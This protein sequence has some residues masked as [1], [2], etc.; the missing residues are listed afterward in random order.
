VA[1][2]RRV[3]LLLS[4]FAQAFGGASWH[5]TPLA[6]ALRGVSPRQALWR[7]GRGRHNIWELVL[8]TAYWKNMVRRR[9]TRDET[10]TF[11]RR[12]ANFPAV[13]AR[14]SA[15]QWKA[16]V[17]LL[18]R[19]HGLLRRAIARL[20]PARLGRR[21]WQSRWSAAATVVGI[22]SHDLYHAGQIQLLKRLQRGAK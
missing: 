9:L 7:P 19:E 16:D 6:G 11:P 8:H 5:G 13:P 14:P 10:V 3:Q 21:V 1:K 15:T 12:G 18:K 22:A 20:A 17:A 2:D 4:V